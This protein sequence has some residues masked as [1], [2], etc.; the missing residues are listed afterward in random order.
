M[1]SSGGTAVGACRATS[2]ATPSYSPGIGVLRAVTASRLHWG[3]YFARLNRNAIS[4]Y[5]CPDM[6][7][8][9][10]KSLKLDGVQQFSW[11]PAEAVMCAY[12]SEQAGGNLPARV[13]LIKIP[14]KVELRQKNLFNVSGEPKVPEG[15]LSLAAGIVFEKG[16]TLAWGL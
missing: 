12:Q 8:L 11:S 13:A 5:E 2:T 14:E 10:K 1:S 16:C 3:R 6:V 7:L 4:I 9:D 15:C